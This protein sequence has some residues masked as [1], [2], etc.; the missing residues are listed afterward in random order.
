MWNVEGLRRI[1]YPDYPLDAMRESLINSIIHRDYSVMGS[2]VHIDIYDDRIEI[3]SPGGMYD[4]RPIQELI[5][6]SRN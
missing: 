2:E 3:T 4:S 6:C 1:E 5:W